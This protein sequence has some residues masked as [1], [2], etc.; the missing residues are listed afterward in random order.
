MKVVVNDGEFLVSV[1]A[2][3]DEFKSERIVNVVV[4]V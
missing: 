3:V 1:C 4:V 2:K